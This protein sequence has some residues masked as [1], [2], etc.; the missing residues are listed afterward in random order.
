MTFTRRHFMLAAP[1]VLSGCVSERRSAQVAPKPR[2]DPYY[3]NMYAA[4]ETEPFP[5]PAV[6]LSYIK[7]KFYRQLVNY[8][9][10]ND[11]PGTIVVDPSERFAYLLM[12]NGQSLRYGVGVAREQAFSLTGEA[13]IARKA[14]WP[15]WRPT[16]SMIKREPD[17]YGP[18]ADGLPGGTQN[19]LGARALYLY[20]NGEDTLYRL[21]GTIEPWTIGTM[22]SSGCVRF[23]NQDIIDLYDRVPVGTRVVIL[24]ASG[25]VV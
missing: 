11:V 7:P 19:P 5:V 6:D 23:L 1:F 9:P 10:I 18:L 3:R 22:V 8:Q 14:A 2:E 16:Q 4:I 13:R 24:P 20:R 21:H 12:D 15:S 25:P 17:R